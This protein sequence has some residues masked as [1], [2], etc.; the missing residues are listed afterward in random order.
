MNRFVIVLLGAVLRGGAELI[1]GYSPG[2]NLVVAL[3]G[4]L[5]TVAFVVFA[6]GLWRST[7]RVPVAPASARPG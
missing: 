6:V 7:R 1:G 3:G 2:W 4:S 5:A